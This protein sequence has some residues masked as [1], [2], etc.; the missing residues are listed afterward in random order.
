MDNTRKML[1]GMTLIH[2]ACEDT[3]FSCRDCPFNNFCKILASQGITAPMQ[4]EFE[5]IPNAY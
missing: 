3:S 1:L 5:R 4:W 2:D